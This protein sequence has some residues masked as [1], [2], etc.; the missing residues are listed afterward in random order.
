MVAEF[1][2]LATSG[3]PLFFGRNTMSRVIG[4]RRYSFALAVLDFL[5]VLLFG[6]SWLRVIQR[7]GGLPAVCGMALIFIGGLSKAVWKMQV[8][9][10]GEENETLQKLFA[11]WPLIYS[12]S[13]WILLAGFLLGMILMGVWGKTLDDSRKSTWIKELTNLAAQSCLLWFVIVY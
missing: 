1:L 3:I 11:P 5:P 13:I 12:R 9:R 10:T 8:C 4:T 7:G 2:Y 6:F